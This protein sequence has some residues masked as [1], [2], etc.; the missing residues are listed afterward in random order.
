MTVKLE[1]LTTYFKF[2]KLVINSGMSLLEC[3]K[4]IF[5]E[6]GW[7]SESTVELLS[8]SAD[9]SSMPK[10]EKL[11]TEIVFG[12]SRIVGICLEISHATRVS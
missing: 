12:A 5:R 11:Q 10:S 3:I 4:L 9:E 2:W 1:G 7:V 8:D 6:P